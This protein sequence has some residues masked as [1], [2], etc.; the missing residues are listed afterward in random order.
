MVL[1]CDNIEMSCVMLGLSCGKMGFI[2]DNIKM[3]CG[4]IGK[5]HYNIGMSC[6]MLRP[7]EVITSHL[8]LGS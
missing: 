8:Q 3:S 1:I 5:I 7:A 4:K 6:D 2:C